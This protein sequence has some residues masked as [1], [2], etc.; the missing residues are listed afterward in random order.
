MIQPRRPR[1]A[2]ELTF[3]VLLIVFSL[4]MLMVSYG[5][6]KLESISSAGAFP[7]V[8]CLMMLISGLIIVRDT[9]RASHAV[10]SDKESVPSQFMRQ[11]APL[12]LALF[13]I[14]TAAYML[15]LEPLG[16]IVS[17]YL[18]L[19]ISMRLLG[20][21]KILLNL[22]LSAVCLVFVYVVFQTAFSV[23]LPAGSWLQ[24]VWP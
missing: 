12:Q 24:K 6:S 18:F 19:V 16:F 22:L 7:M 4:A 13:A 11:I 8:V 3:S 5:I 23:V 21:E 9:A 14:A 1:L 10:N 2:G 15:L 17:S 20:S